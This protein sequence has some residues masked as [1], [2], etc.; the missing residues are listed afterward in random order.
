MQIKWSNIPFSPARV[1]FFYGWVLLAAATIGIVASIPGQTMGVG[2]FTDYLMEELGLTRSQLSLA[3]ALGTITSG[4]L[5]PRA[6]RAI[7]S[8]GIR[9]M[10]AGASVGLGLS[11]VMLANLTLLVSAIP[12]SDISS[13][14]V[15]VFFCFL[16]LRFFG[17]GCLTMVSRVAVGKWF[18]HYRGRAV[19]LMGVA[20]AFSFNASPRFLNYLLETHGWEGASLVLAAIVG[21]GMTIIALTFYRN[22]PEESGL[23]MDGALAPK[24]DDE[25][26]GNLPRA[27]RQF[28]RGEARRTLAFWAFTLAPAAQGLIMT[29]ITFHMASLGE[30][31]GLTRE[32]AYAV[33]LPMA[34]FGVL[35]NIMGGWLSDRIQ[36]KWI[37]CFMM[38]MQMIGIV[39][40]T[41]LD[42]PI[43]RA[44][45]IVG[46]GCS[47]G[48][49]ATMT[50]VPFPRFFGRVHL[51]AVSGMSLSVMVYASAIGPYLFSKG[52][53]I[54]G[55]YQAVTLSC[56]VLPA[57]I[58][59]L[60]W[61]ARNPQDLDLPAE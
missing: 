12:L 34:F 17:Q 50:T 39:G 61:F 32:E 13:A 27:T 41:G 33:F 16:F 37:L 4:F 55:S 3:Y 43:G 52:L 25:N 20:S 14:M 6:G 26:T 48:L 51:G 35:S 57:S 47:G 38:G 28:T 22:T 40:L 59:V 45:L 36:L 7:D 30:E 60:G 8:L 49:F 1:P 21:L 10:G 58:G 56:L 44:A 42:N 5:L 29:A 11:L 9:I 24:S 53:D 19:A 15:A 2:I 23:T 54:F 31:A 46:H 18:N